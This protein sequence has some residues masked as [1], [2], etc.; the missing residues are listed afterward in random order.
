MKNAKAEMFSHGMLALSLAIIAATREPGTWM[1]WLA[2]SVSV[3]NA[4]M[5]AGYACFGPPDTRD[6]RP[7]LIRRTQFQND[8]ATEE[9]HVRRAFPGERKPTE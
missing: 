4:L 7:V 8:F 2:A 9:D 5:C 3:G 6:E 1:R